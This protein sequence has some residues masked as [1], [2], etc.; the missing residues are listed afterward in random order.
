LVILLFKIVNIVVCYYDNSSVEFLRKQAMRFYI[1]TSV[2]PF[3][4][5]QWINPHMINISHITI[6]HIRVLTPKRQPIKKFH[7]KNIWKIGWASVRIITESVH[8]LNETNQSNH[9]SCKIL[10]SPIWQENINSTTS[11][12]CRN[13]TF[14]HTYTLKC[15]RKT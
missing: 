14:V 7:K 4:H 15:L 2:F 13:E 11:K 5:K 12:C 10:R 8:N 3:S 1:R 6:H 9:H